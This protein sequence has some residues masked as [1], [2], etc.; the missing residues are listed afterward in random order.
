MPFINRTQNIQDIDK[1]NEEVKVHNS[2]IN[3]VLKFGEDDLRFDLSEA[4]TVQENTDLDTFI[5]NFVDQD[6][7]L[8]KPLIYDI[9]KSEAKGKHFHNIDYKKELITAPLLIVTGKQN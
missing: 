2:K 3:I 5:S 1:F 6:P 9:A 8:K 7:E 4:F